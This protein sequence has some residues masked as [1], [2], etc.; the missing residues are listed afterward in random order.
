M[1]QSFSIVTLGCKTNQFESAAM[2]E[3]LL[4]AGYRQLDFEA[5]ADLVL[6][7]TCTVTANTD[8]QSRKLIR[9]AQRNNPLARIVVTGCYAQVDAQALAEL[10][11]VSL[12]LG[13]QE[14]TELLEQLALQDAGGRIAVAD[15]RSEERRATLEVASEAQ[16]SRAFLQI[17]NGCDAFCSYCIIPYARGRSRSVEPPAI[18]EQ[19]AALVAAGHQEL[20]L[21]GIHI[22]Q[23]GK[24]LYRPVT[25][26]D[27]IKQIE[28]QLNGARLRLGSLEPTELPEDLRA[29]IAASAQICAHYHIPLQAGAD[30]IL[31]AM[32]RNYTTHFFGELLHDLRARQ[33][34]AGIGIDLIVG[35]PGETDSEFEETYR[36]VDSLPV[37]YLHVFP[38][39]RRPGTPAASLAGQIPGDIARLRAARMRQLGEE[40]QRR[41]ARNFVDLSLEVIAE[42]GFKSGKMRAVADNYLSIQLPADERLIGKRQRVKVTGYRRQGLEGESL[43]T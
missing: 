7:N 26:L 2:A 5:G 32:N 19:V 42:A 24:D 17:Q 36:F 14:K 25:L 9:R 41:F 43:Q 33:P 1:K 15:M 31:Q 28:P 18:L 4:A 12:V 40:K 21:T 34:Q 6:V 16:R 20:V 39:S 13:N 38:Y 27:L 30:R 3:K 23:Y 11:G 35:F 37:S 8:S 29:H 22:G 10:P